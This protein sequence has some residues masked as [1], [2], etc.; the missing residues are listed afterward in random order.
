MTV[1]GGPVGT[2]AYVPPEQWDQQY[3]EIG[4]WSD[5]YSFGVMLFEMATAERRQGAFAGGRRAHT[6]PHVVV[7]GS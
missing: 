5:L 2:P 4:P 1:A 7:R 6:A 3:G